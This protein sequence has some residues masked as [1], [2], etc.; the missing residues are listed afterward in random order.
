MTERE[1]WIL[2]AIK[3]LVHQADQAG[4]SDEEI[5][6]GFQST[7]GL[8]A[9]GV[10]GPVTARVAERPRM[11]GVV[12]RISG[13]MARWDFT[14][15]D[16]TRWI[17]DPA[18]IVLRYFITAAVPGWSMEQTKTALATALTLLTA[19]CAVDF[20]A[21]A[22]A[23]DANILYNIGAIDGPSSTLA[24]C[25]LPYGPQ[26]KTSQLKSLTDSSEP[27]V[28]SADPPNGRLD[29]VRVWCHESGHGLGLEHGPEGCLMAP[30]Y[31]PTIRSPQAWDKDQLKTRYGP[32]VPGA[33]PIPVP[34]T[35]KVIVDALDPS[36]TRWHG[37]LERV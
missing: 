26:T 2:N 14:A 16:G 35:G 13:T 37:E 29:V 27:W 8:V 22:Q 30:Y 24:W 11:C 3:E 19:D 25:E 17:G 9:D 15:W 18:N 5:V 33:V 20:V 12:D 6:A 34:T 28:N 31:D 36:G 21:A 7:H 4:R 10:I 32:R 1:T 23:N